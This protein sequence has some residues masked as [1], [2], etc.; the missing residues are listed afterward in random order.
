M[1]QQQQPLAACTAPPER[2]ACMAPQA[3]QNA[4]S[5]I[6]SHRGKRYRIADATGPTPAIWALIPESTGWRKTPAHERRLNTGSPLFIA[7]LET[8]LSN[9]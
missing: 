5:A 7:V 4:A 6:V 2:S 8:V 1:T 9:L 3:S